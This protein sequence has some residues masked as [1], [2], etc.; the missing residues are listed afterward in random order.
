MLAR[1]H[2][3]DAEHVEV[4]LFA[5]EVLV[6][7]NAHD[8]TTE[9]DHGMAQGRLLAHVDALVADVFG[10][11]VPFL[12]EGGGNV[13]VLACGDFHAF[14]ET[15]VAVMFD[16]HVGMGAVGCDDRQVERVEVP[17]GAMHFDEHRLVDLTVDGQYSSA[18]AGIPFDC[19]HT[20]V[21][22]GDDACAG[23]PHRAFGIRD[24]FGKR[25]PVDHGNGDL[26]FIGWFE[27]IEELLD[28][29]YR[30]VAPVLLFAVRLGERFDVE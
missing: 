29:L 26:R 10:V 7:A 6:H 11:L 28:A 1:V 14:G 19:G 18:F 25:R 2:E 21:R 24:A 4:A 5:A 12:D 8:I 22:L 13:G 23:V 27:H 17:A 15:C 30:R 16:D 9:G 20:V 3:V